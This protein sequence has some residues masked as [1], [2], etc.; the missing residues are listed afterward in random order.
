MVVSLRSFLLALVPF[1][2]LGLAKGQGLEDGLD[3][4]AEVLE[5]RTESVSL[6][7][8]EPLPG[9]LWAFDQT[10]SHDGVD[11]VR[12][13]LPNVSE[14]ILQ[15]TVQG[16]A[17]VSFWWR[18]EAIPILDQVR[19]FVGNRFIKE[20][21]SPYDYDA[22]DLF[23][24]TDSGWQ[25]VVFELEPGE[26]RILWHFERYAS[27]PSNGTGQAWI[28]ELVI[29]PLTNQ[30]DLQDA[31]DNHNY[32]IFSAERYPGDPTYST[33]WTKYAMPDSEGGYVA[34]SGNLPPSFPTPENGQPWVG[35]ST[36]MLEIEGPAVVSFD[37]GIFSDPEYPSELNFLVNGSVYGYV[38]GSQ[39]E[40]IHNRSFNLRPGSHRLT[41]EFNRNPE[42]SE[43]Y[44][45]PIEAYVD[46]LVV[47]NFSEDPD[48]ADA[49]DRPSGVYGRLWQ[50]DVDTHRDGSDAA[51]IVAPEPL[52]SEILYIELPPE[53]GL[54]QF[55]TKTEADDA[56]RL[57][58]Y[59]DNDLVAMQV[60]QQGWAK[61]EL[62][63]PAR[64][65]SI[66][67]MEVV[68]YRFEDLDENSPQTRAF[69]DSVVFL[70]G[71]TNYQPDLS[72]GAKRRGLKGKGVITRAGA[73]QMATLRTDARQ[74][75]GQFRIAGA[76]ASPTDQDTIF[77]RGVG[78]RRH[79]KITFV[80]AEGKNLY[81]YTAAYRTGRFN[82][83][84]LNP[85]AME[86]HEIWIVRKRHSKRRK[87]VHTTVGTSRA[88]PRK[89]D[90]VRSRLVVRP[91]RGHR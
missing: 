7:N 5:L 49:V 64:S 17:V 81:D 34:K 38:D 15:A 8:N 54:L 35:R 50:R 77:L 86:T 12:S 62:N 58:V 72:I 78:S 66:R 60:G 29:T 82:T 79:H 2:P 43:D 76:N 70:P 1:L 22:E 56:G 13:V 11:S 71:A 18:I 61:T 65:S 27:Q 33:V 19:C 25:Q 55:W 48:L 90:A 39:D 51:V 14:S 53:A 88:D 45:G 6:T 73:R 91:Y 57:Y 59:V 24:P 52:R 83:L 63:L 87:Y 21:D 89:V 9:G 31:L 37:W 30:P 40:D 20:I 16:P 46:K 84:K 74:P 47:E 68:F 75:Y 32:E 23:S 67:W 3:V 10:S 36:M 28:D 85:G 4:G 69:V 80:V 26:H 44:G 42:V 41:F